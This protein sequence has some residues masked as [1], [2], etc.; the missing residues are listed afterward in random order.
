VAEACRRATGLRIP[1]AANAAS[2]V[3]L[4]ARGPSNRIARGPN[5]LPAVREVDADA[6][7]EGRLAWSWSSPQS[8]DA[9]PNTRPCPASAEMAYRA[10]RHRHL[11]SVVLP[12][13]QKEVGARLAP[14]GRRLA[15]SHE[16][17]PPD[18][19]M[20]ALY[21]SHQE[22]AL[23]SSDL[24][25]LDEWEPMPGL[26]M[27]RRY[28]KAP[29]SQAILQFHVTAPDSL[30]LGD[31]SGLVFG[32][33][34]GEPN[35][36]FS[37]EGQFQFTDGQV[38]SQTR[39]DQVG[40]AFVREGGD[41]VVQAGARWFT[42]VWVRNYT[43]WVDF[44]REAE[45]AWLKYRQ[46][47]GPEYLTDVGV[48]FVNRIPM[49]ERAVE[50][51]DY[52]RLS[53]DVPAYLPQSV[54]SLFMQVDVPLPQQN[55]TATITSSMLPADDEVGPGGGLLLDIDVKAPLGMPVTDE[56]FDDSLRAT[57]QR[58]RLAKNYVFE[59]CI[60]DA[61]RGLIG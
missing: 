33:N 29:I 12:F 2:L 23:S 45:A 40:F 50:I 37:L 57:L 54:N 31:L 20:V 14:F 61:T 55:V 6:E 27:G 32:D 19:A 9:G 15:C 28:K 39:E 3:G 1:R 38:A 35:P 18:A 47:A 4:V 5:T 49:P 16:H 46:V 36:I 53:V 24:S 59:A 21:P 17:V 42:F 25:Y 44:L 8:Y 41:R 13:A 52:L 30:K 10:D 7:R 34:F 22:A 11:S 58:L 48:R 51:K 26:D 56:R 60:T 43:D